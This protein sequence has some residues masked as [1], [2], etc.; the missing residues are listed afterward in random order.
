MSGRRKKLAVMMMSALG[1]LT[2]AAQLAR[3]QTASPAILQ[4]FESSYSTIERR[5]V[6]MFVAGYG[7][8]W[9]PPPGRADT[10]NQSVGY[11][12]YDR[13]DLGS[14]GAPTLYGTEKGLKTVVQSVQR[15]GANYYVDLVWNHNG[16]RDSSSPGFSSGGGYPGFVLNWRDTSDGDFHSRYAG[17]DLDGRLGGLI[18]IDHGQNIQLIRNPVVTGDTR[19]ITAGP[20]ANYANAANRRFYQNT[21]RPADRYVFDPTTGQGNIPVWDFTSDVATTGV[22]TPENGLGYL[23]RNAQWLVQTI[24]VDGFRLD[25]TKHMPSWVLNYYDR[26]VY[27]TSTRYLLNG[28]QQN[29]FAFG[30]FYD[31][32]AANVQPSI[33]KDINPND[34]G[35]IG[36]N[37]DA[38]DFTLYF[39]LQNNLSSNGYQNDWT[40]VV[41]STLDANDDGYA[42]NGSQGISF[43]NSADV[44]APYLSN[45]AHAYTLM[46]P[47]N[48]LVYFNGK[49]F[50]TNRDFPKDG[51][52]DALGGQYGDTIT[53]LVDIRLRYPQGSYLP[54][55]TEKE[56]MIIER[57]NSLIA[58]YSNRTDSGYD[59]RTVYTN[60]KPGTPLIEL[61]GNASDPAVDPYNDIPPLLVVNG[62]YTV[63]LRVPRNGSS[64]KGYV[65]YGPSGPQGNVTLTNVSSVIGAETPTSSTNGTSRVNSLQVITADSFQVRLQTNRVNLLGSYRDPDADGDQAQLKID[66]GLDLNGNGKVDTVTP[67]SVSY[68]FEEFT[69]IRSPLWNNAEASGL[70]AQNIDA[71]RLS[72]G[73]H[74]LEVRAFR[75]R[76]SGEP[77]IFSSWRMGFIVD[78][79]PA[80]TIVQSFNPIVTGQNEN[81]RVMLQNTDLTANSVHVLLDVP[82][83]IS[84][85]SLLAMLNSTTQAS[86]MDRDLWQED[87]TGL[88]NG[89]HVLSIVSFEQTGRVSVQR[90]AGYYTSTIFGLGFGDVDF[91]GG[92]DARDVINF[93]SIANSG[94]TLF[95]P[96]AD[97]NGDGLVD[98]TDVNLLGNVL[99][100]SNVSDNTLL[101]YRVL[102]G[103]VIPEPASASWL[104]MGAVLL[105]RRGRK[106]EGWGRFVTLGG[107]REDGPVAVGRE[108]SGLCAVAIGD[109]SAHRSCR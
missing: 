101:A 84:Q 52:G 15:T 29:V 94:N 14:A 30:E 102:S 80:N 49:E 109:V 39:A 108:Q 44:F 78:R 6:D 9:T 40:K 35:R 27:R 50:G 63:N 107:R 90:Y 4:W 92:I 41:N 87:L 19:N 58:A 43:V 55:L 23:M 73:V 97:L 10:G 16:F 81:R 56:T 69:T 2:G 91:S 18:D 17:G 85:S 60:F 11:D 31:G 70:F 105:G 104:G 32:S 20:Y 98:Q 100:I 65:I 82:A 59:S 48:T 13:F 71:T 64:G 33:R 45:V 51:R 21:N 67:G 37:R 68:G 93:F 62:D 79:L 103:T 75:H 86:Q 72:E 38:M 22:P 57:S 83:N 96:A 7:G 42:N 99:N 76:N 8:V 74:F 77:P 47:G 25:A 24:G 28:Q 46:R 26:A 12:V 3:G 106:N 34:I 66:G 1:V 89:N 54:R 36:G 61:T 88:T 53:T 5:T 95:N